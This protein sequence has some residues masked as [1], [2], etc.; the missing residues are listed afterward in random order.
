MNQYCSDIEHNISLHYVNNNVTI[1]PCC[2]AKHYPL[3]P[4]KDLLLQP[5]LIEIKELNKKGQLTRDCQAC[6]VVEN[7][8]GHSRRI[9]Q[10][11]FYK[12]WAGTGLRSLD[13]HLG[14]LCNLKCVI[15]NADSSSA[16]LS[17]AR[18]LGLNVA[19]SVYDKQ[20]QFDVSWAAQYPDLEMVHFWGGE[21]MMTPAQLLFLKELKKH[22]ILNKCRL[23]YN[24]NATIIPDDQTV[25]LWKDAHL[26]E[27][28]FSIDDTDLRFEYQRTGANWKN[29]QKNLQWFYDMPTTNHMFYV[30]VTWTLLNIYYLPELIDWIKK[31]IKT[32]RF[33]DTTQICLNRGVGPCQVIEL[34]QFAYNRLQEKYRN[35]PELDAVLKS[36]RIT[37]D[38]DMLKFFSFIN[39]LD[40]IRGVSYKD[41][42]SE[43]AEVLKM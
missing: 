26:V 43:W 17:D 5:R 12:D 35:Y 6:I 1:G 42:H 25:E 40:Q 3:E 41:A 13:L 19:D 2:Q 24:T 9:A 29:V 33:G 16:W 7:A 38:P 30:T 27:I 39:R 21:P 20:N 14:N 31:N 32:N 15:C 36:I 23:I 37:E 11:D 28:Y 10:Q 34:T 4:D 18:A 22:A 8:N